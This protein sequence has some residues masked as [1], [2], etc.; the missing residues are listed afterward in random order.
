MCDVWGYA[1]RPANVVVCE[2]INVDLFWEHMVEALGQAAAVC[3]LPKDTADT[4]T[5]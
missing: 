1:K 2:A 3:V 5:A 4:A